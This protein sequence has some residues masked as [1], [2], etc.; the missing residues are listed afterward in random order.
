MASWRKWHQS[1]VPGDERQ[2]RSKGR[3]SSMDGDW[4][5]DWGDRAE[6]SVGC[7]TI[8]VPGL[9]HQNK[10]TFWGKII[11]LKAYGFYGMIWEY[12]FP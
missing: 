9:G 6:A 5:G 4:W 10:L 12:S 7:C 3:G 1:R 11:I 2:V 8:L